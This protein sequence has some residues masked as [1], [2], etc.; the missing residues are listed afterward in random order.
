MEIEI[1]DENVNV[2]EIMKQI[3][4]NINKREYPNDLTITLNEINNEQAINISLLEEYQLVL[5][6]TWNNSAVTPIISNRKIVGGLIVFVKKVIRKVLGWYINPIVER[7]TEFNANVVKTYNELISQIKNMELQ[8]MNSTIIDKT[9][10]NDSVE[11][12]GKHE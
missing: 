7:Q 11:K 12:K 2:K 5:N 1:D 8:K 3:R 9:Q 4:E 10:N 6:R